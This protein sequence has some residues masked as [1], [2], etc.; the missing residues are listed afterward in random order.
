[1]ITPLAFRKIRNWPRFVCNYALGFAPAAVYSFRN[2][3]RLRIG[4][5]LDHC[6]LSRY[7]STRSTAACVTEQPLSTSAPMSEYFQHTQ[8][9]PPNVRVY[10]YEPVAAFFDLMRT[11]V[12]LNG[13]VTLSAASILRY[14]QSQASVNYSWE[15]SSD[16]D[17]RICDVHEKQCSGVLPTLKD[18]LESND[19]VRVDLLKM[20]CEGSNTTYYSAHLPNIWKGL[21]RSGW[22]I[23][24]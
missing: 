8:S 3:A 5:A 2:G 7:F 13:A 9:Q 18:I 19:L 6:R 1:M 12:L 22:N 14:L 21:R 4:R 23:T 16:V 17:G 15:D 20:D 10:A 24:I 11:N